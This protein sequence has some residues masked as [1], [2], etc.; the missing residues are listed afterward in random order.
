LLAIGLF[1]SGLPS[2]AAVDHAHVTAANVNHSVS[3]SCFHGFTALPFI[4]NDDG[5]SGLQSKFINMGG[6]LV[7]SL[8]KGADTAAPSSVGAF[9]LNV[10]GVTPTVVGFDFQNGSW[11]GPL[12]PFFN[13]GTTDGVLHQTVGSM[14]GTKSF[15][16][17]G[18][19]RVTFDP[20][21]AAQ[22]FP[23]V[24]AGERLSTLTLVMFT[25]SDGTGG[26]GVP[27]SALINNIQLNNIFTAKSLHTDFVK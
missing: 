2:K 4:L 27:G 10:R 22:T 14:L 20:T 12:D 19:T 25:G 1:I 26:N 17:N 11:S 9:I 8:R 7:L 13:L 15:I 5:R 16:G 24:T 6:Q 21:N 3:L 23:V 18:F